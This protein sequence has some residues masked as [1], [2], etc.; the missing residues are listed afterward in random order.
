MESKLLSQSVI[1]HI[2][3]LHYWL[4]FVIQ[5]RAVPSVNI[6]VNIDDETL[7]PVLETECVGVLGELQK[8]RKICNKVDSDGDAATTVHGT[9]LKLEV[10]SR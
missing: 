1:S 7:E 3:A 8:L 6:D 4:V 9:S 5:C 2:I 10:S